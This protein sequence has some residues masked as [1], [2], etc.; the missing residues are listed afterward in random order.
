[1]AKGW[2][3]DPPAKRK[4]TPLGILMLASGAL[5]V[6]FGSRETSDFWVDALKVWWLSVKDKVGPVKRLVIYLDNGRRTQGPGRSGS[7][8]W[9]SL[10]TG[11][12]WR[13]VWYTIRRIIANTIR[14]N[15]VG[16]F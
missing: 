4:W 5:T 16:A 7:S 1:M 15:A 11:R 8:G 2:D 3:H 9:W 13:F 10:R 14:L 12:V 6:I